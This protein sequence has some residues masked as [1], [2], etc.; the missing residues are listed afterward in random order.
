MQCK[1]CI[2]KIRAGRLAELWFVKS[3]ECHARDDFVAPAPHHA[4]IC[5]VFIPLVWARRRP[6]RR[7]R[8]SGLIQGYCRSIF[9]FRAHLAARC[10]K[11][12]A[13]TRTCKCNVRHTEPS[14][15]SI[16]VVILR[17]QQEYTVGCITQYHTGYAGVVRVEGVHLYAVHPE[18]RTKDLQWLHQQFV[19]VTVTVMEH[20]G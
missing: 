12:E 9:G 2:G 20:L 13:L 18:S 8:V 11:L 10:S 14:D 19:K 7:L 16:M 4:V 15:K 1:L 5:T 6:S 17:A 3:R